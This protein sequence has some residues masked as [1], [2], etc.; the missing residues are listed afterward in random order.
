MENKEFTTREAGERLKAKGI[1]PS[2]IRIKVLQYLLENRVHPDADSIFRYISREIPTLSK[3]SIYNTLKLFADKQVV[4][5]LRGDNGEVRY[6]GYTH[7]HAHFMC[8]R[9]E[10]IYDI[11]L[12]CRTCKTPDLKDFKVLEESVYLKGICSNCNKKG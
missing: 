6:D 1:K 9:C 3:T 11:S 2:V 8:V 5:E 12:G 10:K 4:L 7:R